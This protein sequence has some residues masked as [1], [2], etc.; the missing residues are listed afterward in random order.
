MLNI[1]LAN[2]KQSNERLDGFDAGI[3][4]VRKELREEFE[5]SGQYVQIQA[6]KHVVRKEGHG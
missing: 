4:S 1:G 3:A 2:A 6:T 5:E